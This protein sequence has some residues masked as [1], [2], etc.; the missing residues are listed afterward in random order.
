MNDLVAQLARAQC[1]SQAWV[2]VTFRYLSESGPHAPSSSPLP[3]FHFCLELT[4]ETW[5]NACSR[6]S[7]G[8]HDLDHTH[9]FNVQ[10]SPT[11][12]YS[13]WLKTAYSTRNSAPTQEGRSGFYAKFEM[14]VYTFV[15]IHLIYIFSI[16][17]HKD[18]HVRLQC[19]H[20]SVGLAQ[21]CP[22]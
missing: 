11:S 20:A 7:L 13:S 1:L 14:H 10:D 8:V 12:E 6:Y 18:I 16:W 9:W 17:P 2:I 19:S 22:N 3:H 15:S 4:L 21:A 5:A